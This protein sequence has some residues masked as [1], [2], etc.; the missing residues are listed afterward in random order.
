MGRPMLCG[1]APC[2]DGR[3][4]A[5]NFWWL[6]KE[7]PRLLAQLAPVKPAKAKTAPVD[8]AAGKPQRPMTSSERAQM[9]KSIRKKNPELAETLANWADD[10]EGNE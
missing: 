10:L 5:L 6:M 9:I 3:I 2:D 8:R 1:A 7:A 4:F